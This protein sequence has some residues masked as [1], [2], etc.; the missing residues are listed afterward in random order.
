MN[1][2]LLHGALGSMEQFSVHVF[3]FS[4]HGGKRIETPFSIEQ[5][6]DN[7]STYL[8]QHQIKS[9][10]IF[11]YSMGGYVALQLAR[12]HP[13]KIEKIMTLGT[14]F[15]WTPESAENEVRMLVPEVIE[16]KIPKFAETLKNRHHPEDWKKVMR[17]TTKMMIEL[18]NGR[19]M[20][21]ADFNKIQNETMIC[22]GSDDHM[23][24]RD[25]SEKV[26]RYLKK[27]HFELIEGV[28]HPVETVNKI[29]LCQLIKNFCST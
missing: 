12:D 20:K 21:E 7:T 18:G 6:V 10:H 5:F 27:G 9:T 16:S 3:N 22:L 15:N 1:L 17:E 19:A 28:K 13:G 2:I 4:G 26:V 8:D 29:E 25:E 14:K 11:G 23:V 24:T